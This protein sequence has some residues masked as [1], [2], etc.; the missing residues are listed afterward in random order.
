MVRIEINFN[1]RN[2]VF[3]TRL[4]NGSWTQLLET[5]KEK[6]QLNHHHI[7]DIYI[8]STHTHTHKQQ[9]RKTGLANFKSRKTF[10]F[11]LPSHYIQER[12]LFKLRV[13][14][15]VDVVVVAADL[16]DDDTSAV[17]DEE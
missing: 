10:L 9:S 11:Q 7:K 13:A 1:S 12:T 2:K 5:K 14:I 3:I 17:D 8:Y 4:H 16:F 15:V 6:I